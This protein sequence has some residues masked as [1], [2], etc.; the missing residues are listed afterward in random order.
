M[1][2][3]QSFASVITDV[4]RRKAGRKMAFN[5][6][7]YALSF[8]ASALVLREAGDRAGLFGSA[9]RSEEH[10]SELQSL[11]HLVCRL[12][13]EKKK[14]RVPDR[15]RVPLGRPIHNV[16]IYVVDEHLAPVP[17]GAPGEIV[18][19]GVR[20]GRGYINH[21]ERTTRA[22]MAHPLRTCQLLYRSGEYGRWLPEGKLEYLGRRDLQVKI[23]GFRIEIGEIFFFILPAPTE[24]YTLSLHD[25]L[26]I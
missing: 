9:S 7:Q 6:G 3:V 1:L 2:A 20:V 5:V 24:I 4:A 10:T 23:S 18:F 13:L 14:D 26:P 16:R 8:G 21:P 11:R 17:L 22:F 19:S 15:E 12:L 25:A